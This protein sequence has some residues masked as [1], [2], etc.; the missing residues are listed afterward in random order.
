[1]AGLDCPEQ[2]PERGAVDAGGEAPDC[3]VGWS[4]GIGSVVAPHWFGAMPQKN[5]QKSTSKSRI[6]CIF[7]N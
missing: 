1:M 4:L 7:A 3:R 2:G 5:F 6:F